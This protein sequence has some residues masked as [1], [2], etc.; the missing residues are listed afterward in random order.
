[1]ETKMIRSYI[2]DWR[3]IA[4]RGVAAILFGIGTLVWPGVTLWVLV[5]MWGVYAI[6]D[7]VAALAA[8]IIGRR[9]LPHRGWLA[10]TGVVS[11]AAGIAAFVWP[12]ITALALLYLI[13]A[14]AF[15]TGVAQISTAISMRK[16]ITDE[17]VLGIAGV[18]SV[19]LSVLL[20]IAP[21][22]GALA[23]TWAIGWY[24]VVYGGM[25]LTLAW[26][27]RRESRPTHAPAAT[28]RSSTPSTAA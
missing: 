26:E 11:I 12:G 8:A 27:V 1:M 17:W 9:V 7:G 21:G 14:W 2:G 24:A 25:L 4:L 6:V 22:A 3:L 23:I 13:A 20:V 28:A 16:E 19:V 15:V 10:F 18:L 5:L